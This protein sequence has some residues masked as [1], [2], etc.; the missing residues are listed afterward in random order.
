MVVVGAGPTGVELA[1]QLRE[2]ATRTLTGNFRT[3]DPASVRVV[4]VD[5]GAEPLA[6]F[7]DRLSSRAMLSPSTGAAST[8]RLTAIRVTVTATGKRG[9]FR[10]FP[11]APWVV[12]AGYSLPAG[13]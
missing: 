5:G 8:S 7:G 11:T 1:G 10:D 9:N 6:T 4:L 3:I 13:E 12:M 2:L